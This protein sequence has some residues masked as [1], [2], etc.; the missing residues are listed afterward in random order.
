[1]KEVWRRAIDENW[2]LALGVLLALG[3]PNVALILGVLLK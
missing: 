3:A 2:L 1:M